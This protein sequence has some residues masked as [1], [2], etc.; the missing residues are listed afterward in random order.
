MTE[1][2]TAPLL[3]PFEGLGG[4]VVWIIESMG[5]FGAFFVQTLVAAVTPP[6]L[7]LIHI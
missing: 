2:P 7:S 3:R 6:F 4:W 1:P 5:R